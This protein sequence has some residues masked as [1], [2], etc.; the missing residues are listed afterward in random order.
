MATR[1]IRIDDIDGSDG[2]EAITFALDHRAYEID[3]CARNR[4][5]FLRAIGPFIDRARLIDDGEETGATA[6]IV[7]RVSDEGPDPT[8]GTLGD[9]SAGEEESRTLDLIQMARQVQA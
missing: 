6:T 1:I 2:A 5:R 8:E 4:I 9:N 3:L 7:R